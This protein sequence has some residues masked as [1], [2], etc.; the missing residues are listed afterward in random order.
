M[1]HIATQND[2]EV[3]IELKNRILV[4]K[5]KDFSNKSIDTEDLLQ[6]HYSAIIGD[7]ITFPVIFNRIANLKAEI[8]SFLREVQLDF[9]IFEAQ[10]Y[11]EHKK[12]IAGDGGKATESAIEAAIVRD[13]KYK[14]KKYDLFKV[15][16]NADIIDGLYWSAKSK[17]KMLEAISMK[18]KPEEF[19]HEILEG[20]INDVVIKAHKNLFPNKR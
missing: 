11:E 9:K 6:V 18:I 2:D 19:E 14:V 5:I 12:K 3:V 10:K 15:Q 1:K 16:K 7:I 8:D 20:S 4:L 17:G 13:P